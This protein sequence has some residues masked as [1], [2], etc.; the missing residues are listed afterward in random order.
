MKLQN[1]LIGVGIFALF[2]V[3]IFGFIDNSG[4]D[5]KGIYCSNFLNITHDAETNRSISN[6]STVGKQT[7]DDFQGIREDMR[8]FTSNRSASEEPTEGNLLA[9]SIKVLVSLPSSWKPVANVMRMSEEQF[10][11]PKEFTQWVIASIIIIIILILLAA[12]LK[13][14]LQS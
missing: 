11:I 7:D 6:I 2:T 8:G 4:T 10:Q 12:F 9:E 5:C 13:N 1:F 3:I 14:K